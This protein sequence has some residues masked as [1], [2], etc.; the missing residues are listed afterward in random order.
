MEAAGARGLA[1]D[2]AS[3]QPL[4]WDEAVDAAKGVLEQARKKALDSVGA[5]AAAIFEAQMMIAEDPSL[6]DAAMELSGGKPGAKAAIDAAESLAKMF[7][8]IEDEYIRAR[9][10][11][12]RHVGALI[13]KAFSGEGE[14]KQEA[15]DGAISS[16]SGSKGMVIAAYDLS[17]SETVFLDE[18]SVSGI[19]LEGGTVNSHVSI[20]AQAMGIPC[21]VGIKG[22][23]QAAVQGDACFL[24]AVEGFFL[25]GP[26]IPAGSQSSTRPAGDVAQF[27][28]HL[29][30]KDGYNIG[31]ALNIGN[32]EELRK[33][34]RIDLLNTN[35][36]LMRTE[37][38]FMG[39]KQL[40]GYKAQS[41]IYK[42]IM[43]AAHFGMVRFRTLDIGG[44]KKPSFVEFAHEDNP[45]LGL[46]SIRHSLKNEAM[47][48]EQL[49]ALV[50]AS[51]GHAIEVMFPMVSTI[52]ELRR[53]KG[54]LADAIA[55]NGKANRF[56]V[57]SGI[58]LEVPSACIMA[59]AFAKECD[60]LSIGTN[61]LV[62]YTMATDRGNPEVSELYQ[63]FNPA[64]FR[65]INSCVLACEVAGKE[66]SVCGELAGSPEGAVILA[67]LGVKKLSMSPRN[68]MRVAK[69]L[70][71]F[72]VHE[73]R[74][75]AMEVLNASSQQ[76]VLDM[77]EEIRAG[78]K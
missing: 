47:F 26:D 48:K 11:D 17:P 23:M 40:P 30:S 34:A 8:A 15:K 51:E 10:A 37:F 57:S 69:A 24:D 19:A 20:L 41:I 16:S 53:A 62:Q 33:L 45:Y 71:R 29:V 54:L 6:K 49:K 73:M 4:S 70:S 27:T 46:R 31:L 77:T 55:E 43:E 1:A 35:I 5:E 39:A 65:L 50:E 52:E 75:L 9:G 60:F 66:L 67:G 42:Q 78:V 21:V 44:D 74:M 12:I 58:M 3:S 18:K 7:D 59:D 64:I 76:E 28:K 25:T 68:T 22:L 2:F 56:S 32:I 36:G 38:I 61:D 13:A 72:S 63:Q 14:D